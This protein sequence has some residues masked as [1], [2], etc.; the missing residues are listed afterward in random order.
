M[1]LT[2]A[3]LDRRLAWTP[4]ISMHTVLGLGQALAISTNTH[5]LSGQNRLKVGLAWLRSD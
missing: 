2:F 4:P 3:R 1:L 5:C